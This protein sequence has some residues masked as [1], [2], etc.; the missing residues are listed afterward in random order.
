MAGK[1]VGVNNA[2]ITNRSTCGGDKKAG[3]VSTATGQSGFTRVQLNYYAH[4]CPCSYSYFL[5]KN[6]KTC[7]PEWNNYRTVGSTTKING[8][9][10]FSN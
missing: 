3:L 5:K 1:Y 7:P 9:R 8:M 4:N 2:K 10:V 6:R